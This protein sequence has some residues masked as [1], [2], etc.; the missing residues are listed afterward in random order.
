M[1]RRPPSPV[2]W[3]WGGAVHDFCHGAWRHG[4]RLVRT[5]CPSCKE[6]V[7]PDADAWEELVRPFKMK[8]P[9][10]ICRPVGCLECRGTGYLGRMGVYETL[11]LNTA[12]KN[13]ITRGAEL[14]TLTRQALKSGMKPLRISGAMKVAKGLTTIEEVMRVTPSQDILMGEAAAAS[15]CKLQGAEDQGL[16]RLAGLRA[17]MLARSCCRIFGYSLRSVRGEPRAVQGH[18]KD[19]KVVS[20]RL[21]SRALH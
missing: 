16:T 11:P 19:G 12:M 17:E 10:K 13:N 15:S 9:E 21:G 18:P 7:T 4:Q 1:T 14:E 8:V 20:P 6:E 3:I 5:L 2:L